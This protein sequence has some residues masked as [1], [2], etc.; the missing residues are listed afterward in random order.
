M[1]VSGGPVELRVGNGQLAAVGL[2][3]PA[4]G[5]VAAWVTEDPARENDECV[6]GGA[7]VGVPGHGLVVEG[8]GEGLGE[9]AGVGFVGFEFEQGPDLGLPRRGVF[10][11]APLILRMVSLR[12]SR[13]VPTRRL[14][15]IR[16]P[17]IMIIS[18]RVACSG[19]R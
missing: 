14:S 1:S 9:L 4:A 5:V 7:E 18:F 6:G 10:L 15:A 11:P 3:L 13:F 8:A 12:F 2:S 19:Q 17:S 16:V